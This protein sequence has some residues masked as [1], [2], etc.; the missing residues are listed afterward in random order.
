MFPNGYPTEEEVSTPDL[1][2]RFG[3]E[4]A[5]VEGKEVPPSKLGMPSIKTVL[6]EVGR[7]D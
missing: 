4:Y 7:T 2:D 1:W 5:R 3:A 6:R